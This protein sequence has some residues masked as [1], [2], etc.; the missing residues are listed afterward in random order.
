[1]GGVIAV[2]QGRTLEAG[3]EEVAWGSAASCLFLLAVISLLFY[4]PQD[5]CSGVAP[6][7]VGCSV[8]INL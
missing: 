8:C 3:I 2:T 6:L 1:M 4:T 5:H 7:S